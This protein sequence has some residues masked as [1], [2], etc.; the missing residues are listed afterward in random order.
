MAGKARTRA[1]NPRRDYQQPYQ[2]SEIREKFRELAR[3]VLTHEAP[4]SPKKRLMSAID[5][6]ARIR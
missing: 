3:L 4:A 1:E 6:T 5:G 2:H